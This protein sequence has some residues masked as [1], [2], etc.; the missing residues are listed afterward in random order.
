MAKRVIDGLE[1]IEIKVQCRNVGTGLSTARRLLQVLLKHQAIR[2]TCQWVTICL[3]LSAV[4][5]PIEFQGALFYTL[6]KAG[7]QLRQVTV[8]REQ[9][10]ALLLKKPLGLL[11]RANLP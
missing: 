1:A 10:Q 6:L 5:L 2:K 7:V 8:Q 4:P 3:L 9:F 11:A